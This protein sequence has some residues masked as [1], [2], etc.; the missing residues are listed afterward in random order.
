LDRGKRSALGTK[1]RI[2]N[3]ISDSACALSLAALRF[4]AAAGAAL[5]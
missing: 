1:N 4:C 5:P 3:L 2:H